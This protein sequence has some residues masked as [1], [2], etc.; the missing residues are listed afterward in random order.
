VRPQ[1]L[2]ARIAH[3]G[4]G[5]ASGL[6]TWLREPDPP[7]VGIEVRGSSLA[8]LR[9]SH[10]QGQRVLA[11]AAEVRLSEGIL[12]PSMVRANVA[13]AAGLKGAVRLLLERVGA[14]TE[15]R[16]ALALPDTVARIVVLTGAEVGVA[17]GTTMGEVVQFRL[18]DKVP[19]DIRQA[20][21]AW[22]YVSG[23]TAEAPGAVLCVALLRSVLQEY[24]EAVESEGISVGHVEISGLALLR[25]FAA[26]G[27]P[28]DWLTLNW[29]EDH[30][31][32]FLTRD[33][34]PLLARTLVGPVDADGMGRELSNTILYHAERLGGGALAGVRLRSVRLPVPEACEHVARVVGMMPTTIDPLA[35]LGGVESGGLG[36][37]LAGV[38][39]ALGG[40]Q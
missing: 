17:R 22:Q 4:V 24:E 36:Q 6:V 1:A 20:A 25:A 33:G 27:A 39:S 26:S 29:D 28:G 16:V 8:A 3:R 30:L 15:R 34:V 13:D 12:R 31:S 5:V 35:S 40:R 14:L 11:A 38:A 21:V 23:A 7:L 2:G 10:S 32:L 18:R 9:L 37:A 19:F